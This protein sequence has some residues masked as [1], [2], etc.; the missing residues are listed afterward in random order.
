MVNAARVIAIIL[1]LAIILAGCASL[2]DRGTTEPVA[3]PGEPDPGD[4]GDTD[5]PIER[6]PLFTVTGIVLQIQRT[7]PETVIILPPTSFIT[8]YLRNEPAAVRAYP[9][10]PPRRNRIR[11]Q[12]NVNTSNVPPFSLDQDRHRYPELYD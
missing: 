3:E 9:V 11:F 1:V 12:F 8:E 2:P 10:I 7:A 6:D 4:R 5:T